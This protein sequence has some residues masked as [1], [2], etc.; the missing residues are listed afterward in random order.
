MKDDT[1]PNDEGLETPLTPE[2]GVSDDETQPRAPKQEGRPRWA[3]WGIAAGLSALAAAGLFAWLRGGD[4]ETDV[5]VTKADVPHVEGKAIVFSKAFSDRA[6]ITTEPVRLAP[7]VPRLKVVGTVGFD[8]AHVSAVGTRIP[9]LVR[10]LRKV[11]G[12]RVKK[13]DVLAEI[14]SAE[15]GE[16]QA[17]VAVANAH[18][19]AASINEKRERDLAERGLTTAREHEVATATHEEQRAVLEAARQRVI[20]MSGSPGG[21]FGVYML[22][23]PLEGTVVERHIF[24]GQSVDAHLIAFRVANLDHL[25]VE[26][27]VFESNVD[28]I[29]KDDPVEITRVG[30]DPIPG[31]V[32][33]VGEVVD[34]VS[35]TA[36]VRVAVSNTERKLRPGQSVT[37]IIQ[38]SGPSRTMLTVPMTAVTYIDGRPTVFLAES[39]ERVVPTTIELGPDDGK[40]QGVT[41][42]LSEGQVVVSRGVFALKS[43]LYR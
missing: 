20:A 11:E 12:D 4:T 18:R 7:L 41:A 5:P 42:G 38:A 28:A 10:T 29:R 1:N 13:G 37:A 2:E 17:G 33:H 22:R 43:E 14:E 27:S 19:K 36:E 6:G 35:R 39:P 21:P 15:L 8:P 32:A 31:R 9:G 26:L 40:N 34:P 25:W 16:A 30:G 3:R 24:A 23:A